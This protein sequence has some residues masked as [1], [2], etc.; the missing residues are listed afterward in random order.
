MQFKPRLGWKLTYCGG[1]DPF[2]SSFPPLSGKAFRR[3]RNPRD[4]IQPCGGA[5]AVAAVAFSCLLGLGFGTGSANRAWLKNAETCESCNPQMLFTR[6]RLIKLAS[7]MLKQNWPKFEKQWFVCDLRI[8][9]TGNALAGCQWKCL[10]LWHTP[11]RGK[12][13]VCSWVTVLAGGIRRKWMGLPKNAGYHQSI[14][15]IKVIYQSCGY[16]IFR[17]PHMFATLVRAFVFLFR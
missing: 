2:I 12:S 10:A 8:Y 4:S 14:A 17:Q 15:I 7:T 13:L 9:L 11:G 1:L 16:H 5:E 3:V 6:P